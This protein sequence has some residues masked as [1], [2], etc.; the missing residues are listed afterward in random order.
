MGKKCK[1]YWV[2]IGMRGR[3]SYLTWTVFTP[4]QCAGQSGDP[5]KWPELWSAPHWTSGRSHNLLQLSQIF[6][7]RDN[8]IIQPTVYSLLTIHPC[9][10]SHSTFQ[11]R[12]TAGS[13]QAARHMTGGPVIKMLCSVK[14]LRQ[15]AVY[16]NHDSE[17]PCFMTRWQRWECRG[18]AGVRQAWSSFSMATRQKYGRA[19]GHVAVSG[20]IRAQDCRS[21]DQSM[22]GVTGT[23][24][25][26]ARDSCAVP[27]PAVARAW[28]RG[29]GGHSDR[30][31]LHFEQK[32]AEKC[33]NFSKTLQIGTQML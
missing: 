12:V 28:E 29:Q 10:V 33:L 1:E 6:V 30:K 11:P 25:Q 8:L 16:V 32:T 2:F 19:R 3:V 14:V 15:E 22:P 4:P 24:S 31:C 21:L 20:P 27:A 17:R 18:M 23:R 5:L 9:S 7:D 26:A 13:G